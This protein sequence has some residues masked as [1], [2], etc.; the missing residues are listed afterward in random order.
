MEFGLGFFRQWSRFYWW[1]SLIFCTDGPELKREQI[2]VWTVLYLVKEE[3]MIIRC[4]LSE[5]LKMKYLT[6]IRGASSIIG[7]E[8]DASSNAEAPES[9]RAFC[10]IT[11]GSCTTVDI[12]WIEELMSDVWL[13][14]K[15]KMVM[16]PELVR[17][18]FWLFWR[19]SIES[20]LKIQMSDEY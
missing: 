6:W 1:Y 5:F 14:Q 15:K 8:E 18:L 16:L 13:N 11:D 20:G 7:A 3:G 10:G 17:Q 4:F 9:G 12:C 19:A 2:V